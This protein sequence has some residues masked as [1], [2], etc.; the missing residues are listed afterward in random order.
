M[1]AS[2]APRS[3]PVARFPSLEACQARAVELS[4]SLD[5]APESSVSDGTR[6]LGFMCVPTGSPERAPAQR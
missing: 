5:G 2:S 3:T 1:S 6:Q 4:A